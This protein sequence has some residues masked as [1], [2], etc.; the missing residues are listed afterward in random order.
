MLKGTKTG[1][2][3][4]EGTADFVSEEQLMNAVS[5][6]HEA[7]KKICSAID[8][9]QA[10]AGKPKQLDTLR[11]LPK[12]LI[13]NIDKVRRGSFVFFFVVINNCFIVVWG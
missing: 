12:E 10:V 11:I 6:G 1:I 9:F 3:M 2:L 13:T 4:I 7:I 5:V 8:A